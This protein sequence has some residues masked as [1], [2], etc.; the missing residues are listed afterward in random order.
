MFVQLFGAIMISSKLMKTT[1]ITIGG[2]RL[3]GAGVGDK[4]KIVES[5][6]GIGVGGS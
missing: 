6:V 1:C 2:S 5:R 3:S 4:I